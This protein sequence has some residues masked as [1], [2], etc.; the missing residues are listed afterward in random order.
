MYVGLHTRLIDCTNKNGP[1]QII[2]AGHDTGQYNSKTK[3]L[4][5]LVELFMLKLLQKKM[6][7]KLWGLEISNKW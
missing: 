1:T 7:Q 3:S 4:L 5:S 2:F 6:F